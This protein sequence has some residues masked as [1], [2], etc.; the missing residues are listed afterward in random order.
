[1]HAGVYPQGAHKYLEPYAAR[2]IT[3]KCYNKPAKIAAK[4]HSQVETQCAIKAGTY[5]HPSQ[6]AERPSLLNQIDAARHA[7]TGEVC[8]KNRVYH[9]WPD[10]HCRF[11]ASI[12]GAYQALIGVW[13]R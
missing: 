11:L 5:V 1:M 12:S 6:L 13:Q 3:G 8:Q 7:Y 4:H 2:L 10:G 9:I